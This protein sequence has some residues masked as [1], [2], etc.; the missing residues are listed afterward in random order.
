MEVEKNLKKRVSNVEGSAKK[1]GIR[2]PLSTVVSQNDLLRFRFLIFWRIPF[3][4]TKI[5]LQG[6]TK[7]LEKKNKNTQIS[8]IS[9]T[10]FYLSL[11]WLRRNTKFRL[12]VGR[13]LLTRWQV[14]LRC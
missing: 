3:F 7:H 9:N 8:L 5:L 11:K 12:K 2:K 10:I 13:K 1:M 14:S 6:S 4:T